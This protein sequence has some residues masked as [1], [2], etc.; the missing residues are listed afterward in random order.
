MNKPVLGSKNLTI[1]IF[2]V[3]VVSSL[4]LAVYTTSKNPEG[5]FG[6]FAFA[7]E[8]SISSVFNASATSNQDGSNVTTTEPWVGNAGSTDSSYTGFTF[9]N[10]NIPKAATIK[11]AELQ[12]KS[13]SDQWITIGFDIKL[14]DTANSSGVDGSRKLS[15]IQT[16]AAGSHSSNKSWKSGQYYTIGDISSGLKTIVGKSDWNSGNTITV[17]LKGNQGS[18][19][20]KF[21]NGARLNVD[22]TYQDTS[23]PTPTPVMTPTPVP[24][25]MPTPVPTP[26]PVVTPIPTPTPVI[27]PM[28][29][30]MPTGT[31]VGMN[32]H[33][34][35]LWTPN[36]K[37]D[38]CTKAEHDSFKV[39]GPDGKWYPT[40]HPPTMKRADGTTCTFGHEHG[41][42]PSQSSMFQF[43]KE[44]YGYDADHNGKVEGS[45][46][47]T[48]GVPFGYANEQ[49]DVYNASKGI[50]NGMRHEDH[51]GHKIEWEDN[52]QRD[53]STVNGGSGR[54]P[55]GIYCSFFMK[56]HQG[57][58]SKDAF[59]NNMHELIQAVKCSDGLQMATAQMLVFGKAGGFDDGGVAGGTTFV[60]V[61]IPTPANAPDGSG[62]RQIPTLRKVLDKVLVPAGQWSLYSEGI[63]EDWISGNYIRTPNGTQLAYY[64][65]HF[66]VFGP[67][68]F[69]WPGN[70]PNTYGITR[71]PEDIAGNIGRSVDMCWMKENNGTEIARGGECDWAGLNANNKIAY[72]DPKSPFNGVHREFYFNNI[73]VTN[74]GTNR[75]WYSDP[76]GMNAVATEFAGSVKHYLKPKDNPAPY[77]Y[78]FESNAIGSTRS[79]GGNGVHAPD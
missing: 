72:D 45:E 23:T 47:A 63:Y 54:T 5:L 10:I 27:T 30:P 32:S 75:I 56:M 53:W 64:D 15:D 7:Q 33:A 70:D 68:R 69:Y 19:A 17:V 26:T 55:S 46:L 51:V 76:F 50:T 38:T 11:K 42:D 25:P 39:M 61:G 18:F 14:E 78:P 16:I 77:P 48:A 62:Q 44:T 9:S 6:G 79:Y 29:T 67:S 1:A 40:W 4:I 57:T 59:T 43:I 52:I 66:A 37:Y 34:M 3:W 58:H 21:I 24:T 8:F 65:P 13:A 74:V 35:G 49:L 73:N 41:R 2:A 60:N 20:R 36:P 31:T 28:P 71:T 12:V 22:Y